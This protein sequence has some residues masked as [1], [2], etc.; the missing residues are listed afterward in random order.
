MWSPTFVPG[1]LDRKLAREAEDLA[2]QLLAERGTINAS[3]LFKTLGGNNGEYW[4]FRAL[5]QKYHWAT[6]WPDHPKQVQPMRIEGK[7]RPGV[8]QALWDEIAHFTHPIRGCALNMV[9]TFIEVIPLDA[10]PEMVPLVVELVGIP[11]EEFPG[12]T[13]PLTGEWAQWVDLNRAMCATAFVNSP[14]M[15]AR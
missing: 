3:L 5:L 2:L 11:F 15:D 13:D 4:H 7:V 6:D 9:C 12:P 8:P 10:S 14:C 1:S